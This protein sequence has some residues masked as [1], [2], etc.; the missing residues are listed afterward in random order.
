[1]QVLLGTA[2]NIIALAGSSEIGILKL[3][4]LNLIMLLFS[5]KIKPLFD[6]EMGIQTYDKENIMLKL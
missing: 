5:L 1:M 2:S 3:S 4:L 6:N